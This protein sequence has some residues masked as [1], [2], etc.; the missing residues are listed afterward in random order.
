MSPDYLC[1]GLTSQPKPTHNINDHHLHRNRRARAPW[2]ILYLPHRHPIVVQRSVPKPAKS[3]YSISFSNHNHNNNTKYQ[4]SYPSFFSQRGTLNHNLPDRLTH[5]PAPAIIFMFVIPQ[6]GLDLFLFP[7]LC[8]DR[9]AWAASQSPSRA[10]LRLRGEVNTHT[11]THRTACMV[12][13]LNMCFD[14]FGENSGT[15]VL[16]LLFCM[17]RNSLVSPPSQK[18]KYVSRECPSTNN[19]PAPKTL[20]KKKMPDLG[21]NPGERGI[22]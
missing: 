18:K 22:M 17:K 15:C 11:H 4:L 6:R 5:L 8:L 7:R 2:S 14:V 13:W 10:P 21:S 12:G 16:S 1:T 9:N 3:S 20:P 19:I